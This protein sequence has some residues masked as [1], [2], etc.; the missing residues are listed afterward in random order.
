MT[1]EPRVAF[2]RATALALASVAVMALV[3][4]VRSGGYG[5]Q[6]LPV[7]TLV[8]AVFALV[9]GCVG[10]LLARGAVEP[11][12]R[13]RLGLRV[14]G[15]GLVG[16][17]CSVVAALF[18]GPAVGAVSLPVL[19]AWVA[20]GALGVAFAQR[21]LARSALV[22]GVAVVVL[23]LVAAL[24]ADPLVSR[25][26][27]DQQLELFW[28]WLQPRP[29]G[30]TVN[31]SGSHPLGAGAE[32]LLREA[33]VRGEV[34]V[35]GGSRHGHGPQ[36]TA[37]VVLTHPVAGAVRLR[38]PDGTAAVY[39]QEDGRFRLYPPD[40][41]TRPRVIEIERAQRPDQLDYWVETVGGRTGG[42]VTW[43]RVAA[44]DSTSR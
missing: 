27:G 44:A 26:R 3:A 35:L 41:K 25:L 13:W 37:Y 21:R 40:T 6:D 34:W 15:G 28:L 30:L 29:Q 11:P 2:L 12:S 42:H 39:V 8:S 24:L 19:P 1:V 14:V 38:Q 16:L 9:V 22:E 43:S 5:L 18:F 33:G 7:Y 32:E 4:L 20:G 31:Q 10:F 23:V 17:A 36:A